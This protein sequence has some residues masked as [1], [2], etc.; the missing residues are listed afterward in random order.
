L[1]RSIAGAPS[2][3]EEGA[4]IRRFGAEERRFWRKTVQ[5]S[6]EFAGFDYRS[7]SCD[8]SYIADY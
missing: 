7:V 4:E 2:V 3:K 5:N 1:H 6:P 8:D